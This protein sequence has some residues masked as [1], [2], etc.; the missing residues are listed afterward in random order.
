MQI[1]WNGFS[2]FEITTKTSGGDVRIVTDPYQNT[3]GLRFPRTLEAEI[4]LESHKEE[5]ANNREA[6]M[7][8]PYVIDLPGEFEVR[9][10]FVFGV[11]APLTHEEKGRKIQNLLFRIESEGMR[12]AHL[13]ALDRALTDDELQKL[14]NIDILL[15]PVGG[16]RV[17]DPKVAAE[18]ISQIEPRVVIPMTH[19]LPGMKESFSSID[20]F[21]KAFGTCR[22]EDMNK[23]KVTRK[24]LPEDDMLILS[25]TR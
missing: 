6:V 7:G 14:E 12:L 16:G 24:D 25:L 19:A 1:S 15:I 18:V 20:D 11:S 22:R 17:M 23:Y 5:D 9:S 4:L 2:S 3:T 21:C 10:V 8:S 13:G